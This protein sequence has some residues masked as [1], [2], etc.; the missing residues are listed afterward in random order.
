MIEHYFQLKI[1]TPKAVDP[2]G[3]LRRDTAAHVKGHQVCFQCVLSRGITGGYAAV[4]Q[5]GK[6]EKKSCSI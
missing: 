6:T 4:K 5:V 1:L 2:M 3:G